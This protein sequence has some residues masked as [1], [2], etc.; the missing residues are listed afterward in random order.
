M[1]LNL[2]TV[3]QTCPVGFNTHVAMRFDLTAHTTLTGLQWRRGDSSSDL[4][5]P[6]TGTVAPDGSTT[7][8][9]DDLVLGSVAQFEVVDAEGRTWLRFSVQHQ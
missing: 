4:Y 8:V 9:I 2:V 3:N 5:T 7:V 1:E 6:T